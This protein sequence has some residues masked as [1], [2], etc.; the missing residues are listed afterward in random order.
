MFIFI[1]VSWNSQSS[2]GT[3]VRALNFKQLQTVLNCAGDR[4]LKE[5]RLCLEGSIYRQ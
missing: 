1:F 2:D 5:A 3:E 4:K